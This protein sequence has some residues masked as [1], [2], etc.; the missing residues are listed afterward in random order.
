MLKVLAA[1]VP[2]IAL[3][4]SGYILA[5]M[6]TDGRA[7]ADA[8]NFTVMNLFFPALL[9]R[10]GAETDWIGVVSL[11]FLVAFTGGALITY[12]A[13]MLLLRRI[14]GTR[15]PDLAINGLCGSFANC[16]FLGLPI[17]GALLG[18]SGVA[19]AMMASLV[20]LLVVVG[21][22]LI[23][24]GFASHGTFRL[25]ASVTI[26]LRSPI[27]LASLAGI[28][29]YAMDLRPTGPVRDTLVLIGSAA[30]PCALITIGLTLA[31]FPLAESRAVWTVVVAKLLF[32]PLLTAAL[33]LPFELPRLWSVAAILL[34]ALPTGAVPALLAREYGVDS[35]LPARASAFST[36]LSMIVMPLLFAGLNAT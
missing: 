3:I 5:K 19:A 34:A 6:K 36:L 13:T 18:Q 26:L 16:A 35:R 2:I 25:L 32:Q 7:V 4:G 14:E 12:G 17:A 1:F 20:L 33:L 10:V 30:T 11:G 27:I 23:L 8:L 22:A 29:L 9:L 21:I 31:D 24:L 28:A 15:F